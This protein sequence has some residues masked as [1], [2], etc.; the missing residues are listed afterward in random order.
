MAKIPTKTKPTKVTEVIET[1]G[2]EEYPEHETLPRE[3][4]DLLVLEHRGWAESIARSVARGWNLDWQMDGLD[5]AAMEALIF[6][7]RRFQPTR[8]VP[9]RGYA[10]RRI[11]EAATEAARK[12]KGWKKSSSTND[13]RA[14]EIS[15]KLFDVFP[16]LHEGG[17][18]SG[19]D[20]D[21]GDHRS[22]IRQLLMGATILASK[23]GGTVEATQDQMVDIKRMVHV[24]AQLE[25]VHQHLLYRVYWDGM[26][27]RTVAGE[28]NTDGLNVIREHKVL[29]SHLFKS[30]SVG[31]QQLIRPKI[32]PG[33]RTKALEL[34]KKSDIGPF[35]ELL[36][37]S[38]I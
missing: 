30:M 15:A 21:D 6:C 10:R 14:R 31:K 38:G 3:E 18:P 9:F 20:G 35:S 36:G 24:M 1:D 27:L 26:S 37:R 4:A 28:W 34:K 16:E 29:L 32:R 13:D 11:H 33:L 7:A 8:G 23:E 22:G 17:L 25:P 19:D 12:S 2:L 5:G